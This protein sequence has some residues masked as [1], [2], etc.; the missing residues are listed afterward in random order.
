MVRVLGRLGVNISVMETVYFLHFSFG[1]CTMRAKLKKQLKFLATLSL[2]ERFNVGVKIEF[3]VK[4]GVRVRIAV[5][6][7]LLHS[8]SVRKSINLVVPLVVSLL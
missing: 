8:C 1:A 5:Q 2:E 7:L 3:K 4:V 6:D